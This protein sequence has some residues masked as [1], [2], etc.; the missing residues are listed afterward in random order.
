MFYN[1]AAK[2]N[3][4]TVR[5]GHSHNTNYEHNLVGWLDRAIRLFLHLWP[6]RPVRLRAG[7][8]QSAVPGQALPFPAQRRGCGGL[9]PGRSPAG[10]RAQAAG[11]AGRRPPP[12]GTSGASASRKNHGYLLDIFEQ[13]LKRQHRARLVLLGGRAKRWKQSR[14]KRPLWATG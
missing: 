13:I 14:R 3:G 6:D 4:I 2:K 11:R 9:W 7:G 12:M 8:G 1:A 5:A 10:G